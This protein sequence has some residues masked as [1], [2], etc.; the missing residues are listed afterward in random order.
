[1]DKNEQIVEDLGGET[2][3]VLH[4]KEGHKGCG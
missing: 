4:F 1:V 3:V 2:I